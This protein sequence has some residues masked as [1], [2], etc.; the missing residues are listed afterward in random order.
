MRPCPL[1]A[2]QIQEAAIK[3]RHC[4]ADLVPAST[5]QAPA[6]PP[7]DVKIPP[8]LGCVVV[9]LVC[10]GIGGWIFWS[11]ELDHG[12][13]PYRYVNGKEVGVTT[14]PETSRPDPSRAPTPERPRLLLLSSRGTLDEYYCYVEGQVKNTTSEALGNVEAVVTWY[15]SKGGFVT[16]SEA[17][18]AY[19][20]LLAGQT[21]PFKVMTSTNPEM[22]KFNVS[23]K[24]LM[25]G[26][27]A[28]E[29]AGKK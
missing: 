4:G 10:L 1:C 17:L 25:G 26:Q 21:S 19:N 29:A 8:A 2:E 12:G 18:I 22:K 6:P 9:F 23:F 27:I 15:D 20:P 3:C 14:A 5:V 16:T 11:S 24:D 28:H 13:Q 7:T